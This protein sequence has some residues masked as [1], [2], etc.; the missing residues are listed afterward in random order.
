MTTEVLKP[1][2]KDAAAN[3]ERLLDAAA[4]VFAEQGIDACVG[5]I[6]ARAE[7][8]MGTFYRNFATKQDLID[9]LVRELLVEL[10]DVGRTAV[11]T[12]DSDGLEAFLTSA[13]ELQEA[14][15]GCLSHLWRT[16][17]VAGQQDEI[18]SILSL[19][20]KQSQKAGRV[21]ADVAVSDIQLTLFALR[22]VIESTV[23]AA[24]HAWRR[25]LEVAIAGLRPTETKL[26]TKVIAK[27]D[28]D[29]ARQDYR[30][31]AHAKK[32]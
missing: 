28:I 18:D 10:L 15:N 17:S 25:Y 5:D 11:A 22:G 13:G 20:L 7:I 1:L 21:R 23:T 4:Q 24:P 26:K 8:G 29:A 6:A 30:E 14:H 3:R 32:K 9:A 2:R 27:T 31:S 12:G 16:T 19:L